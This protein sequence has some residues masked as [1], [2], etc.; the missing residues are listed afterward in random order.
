MA[1]S[2]ISHLISKDAYLWLLYYVVNATPLRK[3]LS[4]KA[5]LTLQY[6]CIQG[7]SMNWENPQSFNEKLQWL[8]V[9]DHNPE[10]SKMVDKYEAKKYVASII[11]EEYIIPTLGV[12]D[13][14]DDIDWDTLPYQFVLKCTHDSGGLVVCRDKSKLDKEAA[15]KKLKASFKVE[16]YYSAR[17]W[18]YKNVKPRVIAEKYMEGNGI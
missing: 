5:Y 17:E 18:P 14:I 11:G 12:W 9:Y 3:W 6:R 15:I 2:V 4:D 1:N 7:K 10:Y 13:S 16:F 8:K